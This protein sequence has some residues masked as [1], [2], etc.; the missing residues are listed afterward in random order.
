MNGRGEALRQVRMYEWLD[1][2]L[3]TWR[4]AEGIEES[5]YNETAM[6]RD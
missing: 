4:S 1:K 3:Y 2:K 6:C 5:R